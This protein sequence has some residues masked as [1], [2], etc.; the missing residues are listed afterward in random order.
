MSLRTKILALLHQEGASGDEPDSGAATQPGAALADSGAGTQPQPDA[1]LQAQLTEARQQLAAERAK[2]YR[3][4]AE[5]FANGVKDR[6]TPAQREPLVN[7]LVQAAADDAAYPVPQGQQS[8]V[9]TIQASYQAAPKHHLT[10][11]L[12]P[13]NAEVLANQASGAKS[14]EDAAIER[15]AKLAVR[16]GRAEAAANGRAR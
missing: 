12:V 9:A 1:A 5:A 15:V 4:A 14:E 7:A 2:G 10:E 13:A 3:I 16:N 8:R 6:I 11:E